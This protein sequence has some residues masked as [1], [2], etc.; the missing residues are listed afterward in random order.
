M[1]TRTLSQEHAVMTGFRRATEKLAAKK[2]GE[3]RNQS[4][5]TIVDSKRMAL[6]AEAAHKIVAAC[7]SF[8]DWLH[9][10][11]WYGI[12]KEAI[13]PVLTSDVV[14]ANA[15][16]AAAERVIGNYLISW[17]HQRR[18][19]R[20]EATLNRVRRKVAVHKIETVYITTKKRR[21]YHYALM[22]S[23]WSC[24]GGS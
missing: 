7:R 11:P 1:L 5:R 6:E 21:L 8:L 4:R 3:L 23:G 17:A 2:L 18:D 9:K 16:R 15:R 12:S 19:D 14:K 22:V 10:Q 24:S 20:N 13:N